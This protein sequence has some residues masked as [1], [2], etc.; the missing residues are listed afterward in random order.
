MNLCRLQNLTATSLVARSAVRP[1]SNI[2][3]AILKIVEE[4]PA[5][6][7]PYGNNNGQELVQYRHVHIADCRKQ[8]AQ[9]KHPGSR[10]GPLLLFQEPY[11]FVPCCAVYF[12]GRDASYL[13]PPAQIRTCGFPAY[14]SHLGYRRQ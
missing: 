13:A 12:C 9:K 14:G 8:S 1:A 4:Q 7:I 10:D 6:V 5:S 11:F 2:S 3:E